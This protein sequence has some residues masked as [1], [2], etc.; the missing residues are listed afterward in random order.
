VLCLGSDF[1]AC[2]GRA[3]SECDLHTDG[4]G[5]SHVHVLSG[6]LKTVSSGVEMVVIERHVLELEGPV[7]TGLCGSVVVR[8]G[9]LNLDCGVL[10]SGA[11]RV[12]H[13]AS[14]DAGV[15][16]RLRPAA[17]GKS[18]CENKAA[19]SEQEGLHFLFDSAWT[20]ATVRAQSGQRPWMAVKELFLPAS[21]RLSQAGSLRKVLR[22]ELECCTESD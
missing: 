16:G 14:N 8:N 4:Q 15:A 18:Q 6:H 17:P 7:A 3:E 22:Q 10:D 12:G 19:A 13:D 20:P 5:R 1:N 11:G 21:G 9:I 2:R